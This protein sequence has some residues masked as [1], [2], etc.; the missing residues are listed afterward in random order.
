[1]TCHQVYQPNV[2]G[3]P[4]SLD[5]TFKEVCAH[6][7][8]EEPELLEATDK[9]LGITLVCSPIVL[10]P[11]G[12][13]LLPLI[14][15]KNELTKVGKN[16]LE[17]FSKKKDADYIARQTRMQVAYGLICFTAFFEALDRQIPQ[18]IR[19]KIRL[20]KDEK[21]YLVKEGHSR[22]SRLARRGTSL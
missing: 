6:I 22:A 16:V 9:L 11:L 18:N 19:E 17:K 14:A 2:C 3:A 15:V 21:A 4:M 20:L 5:L 8:K 13:G 12:F 7:Q 10:G 1:M